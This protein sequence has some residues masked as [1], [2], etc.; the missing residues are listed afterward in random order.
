MN[1][2]PVHAIVV[3]L[4]IALAVL[5]P[6]LSAGLLAAWWRGLLPAGPG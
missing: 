1:P 4:P 6:V 5:M 2:L 3:H